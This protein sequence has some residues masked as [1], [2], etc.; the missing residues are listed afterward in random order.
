MLICIGIVELERPYLTRKYQS[1]LIMTLNSEQV[2][3][4]SIFN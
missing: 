4:M 2:Q 1:I 3:Q